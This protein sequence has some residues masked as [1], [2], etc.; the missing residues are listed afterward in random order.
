MRG[1]LLASAVAVAS[2]L[3]TASVAQAGS[4]LLSPDLDL[5]RACH[6]DH[7]VR[8]S[9][10]QA[11]AA[12][13]RRP[14]DVTAHVLM[15]AA[16]SRQMMQ[17]T[18]DR[19]ADEALHAEGVHA[20]AS[21]LLR[22]GE[23]FA[24]DE[25][26][27][28]LLFLAWWTNLFALRV[29]LEP[30]ST[31]L[32][33][34]RRAM[35]A[36][37]EAFVPA[38]DEDALR[39]DLMLLNVLAYDESANDAVILERA[40]AHADSEATVVMRAMAGHVERVRSEDLHRVLADRLVRSDPSSPRYGSYLLIEALSRED[41]ARAI[42]ELVDAGIPD[43]RYEDDLQVLHAAYRLRRYRGLSFRD[44]VALEAVAFAD[45]P[46]NA[47]TAALTLLVEESLERNAPSR[48]LAALDRA[49][50]RAGRP[51]RQTLE[52]RAR[53]LAAR[54]DPD[55]AA[56]ALLASLR[57]GGPD[58]DRWY[59]VARHF[60]EA[61]NAPEAIRLYQ[62]YL[63]QLQARASGQVPFGP[64]APPE[65]HLK[66]YATVWGHFVQL[67]PSFFTHGLLRQLLELLALTAGTLYAASRLSRARAYLLP[68]AFAA[69]VTFLAGL[70]SLRSD[71]TPWTGITPLSW[72]WLTTATSR[73]FLLVGAGLY[74]SAAAGYPRRTPRG[75]R[76][77][78]GLATLAAL[79]AGWWVGF[80]DG[81]LFV[82][83]ELPAEARVT[84]LGLG[85]ERL[86]KAPG[87][88]A[89]V[90]RAEAVSRLL[91]PALAATA[92]APFLG[93][94]LRR[95]LVAVLVASVLA[96]VGAAGAFVPAFAGAILLVAARVRWGAVAPFVVH[97]GFVAGAIARMWAAG[98]GGSA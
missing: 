11:E 17:L 4:P 29:E 55:G 56:A 31:S 48:A 24:E 82:I 51:T 88:L 97:G 25:A 28:E 21:E 43:A 81:P 38:D 47:S 66:R 59:E 69:E 41:E 73:I 36:A 7:D 76:P 54:G 5:G 63:L 22:F 95:D 86:A 93:G 26:A 27:R 6:D 34:E 75:A 35:I 44:Q 20:L 94:G 9:F 14:D 85:P 65:R 16:V 23:A 1:R 39:R 37:L 98:S 72:L 91:W 8:C 84:E 50:S 64:P 3:A 60:Q 57:L 32:A 58:Y 19:W 30:P 78:L 49:D 18:P 40:L 13:H 77:W 80:A 10:A 53:S 83:T 2:L 52:L 96:A 71:G 15:C 46:R 42:A 45:P 67:Q 74:L 12:L 62:F 90:L 92:V 61:G 68:A 89:G 87:V 70:L 79:A 33:E